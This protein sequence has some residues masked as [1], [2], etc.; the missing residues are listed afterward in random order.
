MLITL[1]SCNNYFFRL[2]FKYKS[3]KNQTIMKTFKT[4][5]L[6]VAIT[7]SAAIYASTEPKTAE[8]NGLTNEIAKLLKNPKF[9]VENELQAYVT[10][11]FNKHH[12]IVV[13]SVD[14]ENDELNNFI[15]S[16]LNYSKVSAKVDSEMVN[17]IIPV[18]LTTK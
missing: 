3:I 7:F 8:P 16:R 12:E 14:S 6:L 10:I 11:T 13:L 2:S 4:L 17:Y 1:F 18:R 15:K 9:Q 5:L